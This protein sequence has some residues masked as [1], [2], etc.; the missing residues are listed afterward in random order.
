[1]TSINLADALFRRSIPGT[2]TTAPIDL[3]K[4]FASLTGTETVLI[5]VI[6]Q[7]HIKPTDPASGDRGT[8]DY[9]IW[10]ETVALSV[11]SIT[12]SD[13]G[14]EVIIVGTAYESDEDFSTTSRYEF[15]QGLPASNP[16]TYVQLSCEQERHDAER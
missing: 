7:F 15:R 13:T 9:R 3:Q 6:S 16:A 2:L 5:D 8:A 1:M 10:T 12:S 11:E 14:G 4:C